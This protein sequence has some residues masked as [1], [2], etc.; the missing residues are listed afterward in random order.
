LGQ[1]TKD[2]WHIVEETIAE[3][4]AED[5]E[6]KSVGSVTQHWKVR[7]ASSARYS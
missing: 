4:C 5:I 2:I 3:V 6:E 7:R 1:F